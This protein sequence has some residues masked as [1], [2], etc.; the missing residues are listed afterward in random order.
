M[1]YIT[2]R[3][4]AKRIF[5]DAGAKGVSVALFCT[6]SFWNTEAILL[7]AGNFAEK[8][9]IENIPVVV[10]MTSLYSHMAQAKRVSYSRDERI[11]LRAVFDYCKMLCEGPC[12]PYKNV[13]VMAHLDHADPKADRRA[14][15]EN[16]DILTSVMFDAQGYPYAENLEMT[17]DYVRDFGSKVLVE[18]I[19]ENLAVEGAPGKRSGDYV[20]KA[21]DFI[22][23]TGVDFLVADLGTE[24]QSSLTEAVYLGSRA[25][26]LTEALGRKMLV[27]HGV[28]SMKDED[29]RG[30]AGDGVVRVNMW[31]RIV[32]TS[33]QYAAKRLMERMPLI[34]K[35]DFEAAEATAY[36]D[37]NI[38]EAARIMEATMDGLGYANF[39]KR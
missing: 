20:E 6:G 4:E 2:D 21:V 26:A 29:I 11:G 23:K 7:A 27:L 13:A 10:A 15:T 36:I 22:G 30:L 5:D 31:T 33:G 35:G 38:F 19:I 8:H 17:R 12:A 24:Q 39:A 18:G 25:R 34:E 37:D 32:R 3:N 1:P 14:L 9:G 16:T 28:S